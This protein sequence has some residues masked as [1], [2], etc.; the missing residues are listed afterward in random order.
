MPKRMLLI[1]AMGF[2]LGCTATA[3]RQFDTNAINIIEINKTTES[4][5]L[6]MLGTPTS[7]K[8]LNNGIVIY[9]YSYGDTSYKGVSVGALQIQ[10]FDGV[11]INKT[12][13]VGQ[14]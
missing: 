8:E 14:Y 11:V 7:K 4:D 10:L 3:G 9:N 2:F 13:R 5:V 6:F 1:I 12:Q